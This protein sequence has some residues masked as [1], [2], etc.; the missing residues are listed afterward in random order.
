VEDVVAG[1]V[2]ASGTAAMNLARNAVF[3]A[4]F[5]VTVSGQTLDRQ[6]ASGLMAVATAAKQVIVDGMDVVLAGGH[7]NISAV[8]NDYFNWAMR[9]KDPAV[10]EHV[11]HA[12]MN[13]LQTAEHVAKTYG[14][15]REVQDAYSLQSQMRVVCP[16]RSCLSPPRWQWL[17]KQREPSL[18]KKSRSP[19]TKAIDPTPRQK[20]WP[21]SNL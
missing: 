2:L 14:I 18:T 6:C 8:Q 3:A 12:Y 5:P 11:P 10:T 9:E 17:T 16:T 19:W 15:S 1:T 21:V 20:D 4:G 7:D 13:M